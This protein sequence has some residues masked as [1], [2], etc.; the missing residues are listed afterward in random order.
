MEGSERNLSASMT[1]ESASVKVIVAMP[2]YNEGRYIG[3]LIL[4]ARQYAD[5]VI[6]VDDGSTDFTTKVAKL[7]GATVIRHEENKG[8]GIAI[9]SILAE[10]KKR[11]PDILIT[12]DADSQHNPEEIPVLIRAVREGFDVV[13]G[14]RQIEMHNIPRY[15]RVGQQVLSYLTGIL[16]RSRVSD[17]ES[18]FRS[19]SRRAIALL[20]PRQK[21]FGICAEIVAE[22]NAKGLKVTEIPVTAIYTGDGS[23][24]NPI[25]HGLGNLNQI[26]VMISERRPLL[27]FGLGGSVSIALGVIAGVIV[28]MTFRISSILATGTALISMLFITIGILSIFTGVILNALLRR[29]SHHR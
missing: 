24:L 11:N 16:S 7:A 28:V 23:T 12:L 18:G 15:R 8:Y 26:M 1:K 5:E 14:S 10:V 4:Q 2:A 27:F 6:V 9:Q 19:Y 20:E 17:T 3:S 13:I 21:G 25:R 29:I 22:A